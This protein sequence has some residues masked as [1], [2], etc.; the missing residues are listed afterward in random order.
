MERKERIY[1]RVGEQTL[2]DN[3]NRSAGQRDTRKQEGCDRQTGDQ[4][5]THMPTSD[6]NDPASVVGRSTGEIEPQAQG[7][8]VRRKKTALLLGTKGEMVRK[9]FL[10]FL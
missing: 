6:E 9:Q 4:P 1:E 7:A 8:G 5:T 2:T 3:R 10:F